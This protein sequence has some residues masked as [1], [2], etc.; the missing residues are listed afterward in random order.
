MHALIITFKSTADEKKL[1]AVAVEFAAMLRNV[2][3]LSSKAWLADGAT[4]GGFYLFAD[5]AAAQGYLS[6]PL[7]GA[8]RA[9]PDF[10]DFTVREFAVNPE[11][12]ARTGV[13]LKDSGQW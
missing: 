9:N 11:L 7:V 12:S 8:L 1:Q 2:T 10:S 5:R 3:G 13:T 6:G 4:Q